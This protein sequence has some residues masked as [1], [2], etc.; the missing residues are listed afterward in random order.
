MSEGSEYPDILQILAM[1]KQAGASDLHLSLGQ[2]PNIRIQGDLSP[3]ALPPL[4]SDTVRELSL[5]MLT[6]TQRAKLEAD[7]D[8]DFSAEI[9]SVGRIRGNVHYSK[10]AIEAAYRFISPLIPSLEKLGHHPTVAR[11]CDHHEG[12]VLITGATGSGK[13]TTLGAMLEHINQHRS[14][15]VVV[16]EDPIEFVFPPGLGLI[17]QREVGTDT[18]S[19]AS[20][21]RH[22][23]RQDPD[24]IAVTELRDQESVEI[25]LQAAET[26]HLVIATFHAAD[27]PKAIDRILEMFGA[28][29]LPQLRAQLANA[30]LAIISQRLLPSIDKNSRALASEILVNNSAVRACI[31]RGQMEHLVGMMEIGGKDGMVTLDSSLSG[32]VESNL[33][34]SDEALTHARDPERVGQAKPRKKGLFG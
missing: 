30:L 12:L 34:T 25:A 19:F 6:E 22:A 1:A 5:S 8:L 3:L 16:L 31:R 32:L 28:D 27:P 33:I 2:P 11:L 18:K 10:G 13:S 29:M 17:K 14:G 26:G 23:L 4:G 20:G 9:E 7:M 15:V 24:V 21:L